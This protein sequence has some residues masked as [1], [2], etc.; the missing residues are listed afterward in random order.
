LA[1][2]AV[3][4]RSAI[5][6]VRYAMSN[7]APLLVMCDSEDLESNADGAAP[8]AENQPAIMIFDT[9]PAGIGLSDNLYH[10]HLELL[11]RSLDLISTCPCSD[12]CPSC[13]GPISQDGSG[14]KEESKRLLEL[15][16]GKG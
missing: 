8:Y 11:E 14:G 10:K 6:G 13:V 7:L 2:T 4:I 5:S 15:L 9:I 16:T 1:E 12:G 3:R